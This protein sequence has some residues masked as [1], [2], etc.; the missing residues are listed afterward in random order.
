VSPSDHHQH[1]LIERLEAANAMD[2]ERVENAPARFR[3]LDDC[4]DRLSVM[5]G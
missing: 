5:P 4:G 2:D 3:L 1:D